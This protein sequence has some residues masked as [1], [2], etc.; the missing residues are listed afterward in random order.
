MKYIESFKT[1]LKREA[2]ISLDKE[3]IS[4]LNAKGGTIYVGVDDSGEVIGI[5]EQDRDN[6]DKIISEIITNNIKP[7]PRQFIKHY[8][9]DDD[10]LVIEI[11]EGNVKPYYLTKKG[12]KNSGTFIRIGTSKRECTDEEILR[13]I[14]DSRFYSYENEVSP[15]QELTFEKLKSVATKKGLDFSSR[16]YKTLKLI[17]NDNKYTRLALLVSDQ[18]DIVIKLAV[19]DKNMDFIIKKDING[20]LI[21]IAEE[22]L[23]TAERCNDV[24]AVIRNKQISRIE[25]LSYPFPSLRESLLNALIHADYAVPSNIKVD[26]FVDKVKI[27]NPGDV[28][29]STIEAAIE[30]IQTF[31][32]PGLTNIFYKLGFIENYGS[33]LIRIINAY[34]GTGQD[35]S[36][37]TKSY[38]FTTTLPNLNFKPQN[39]VN[40]N[41]NNAFSIDSKPS[42]EEDL[43]HKNRN[44]ILSQTEL[45]I[46][47]LIKKN[48]E[49]TYKELL[50]TLNISLIKLRINLYKLK[51][52][53]IIKRIGNRKEGYFKFLKEI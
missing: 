9:N 36:F 45:E 7:V 38:Y 33:G 52:K 8:F 19:Y 37:V 46:L 34:K 17:N 18:N 32:N 40:I 15:I 35:P 5:K 22:L 41:D 16:K 12:P 30:G 10:V 20:S 42:K 51:R 11:Q 4:F 31:R 39:G 14:M 48:K 27:S 50:Y 29:H 28:Y 13:F 21:S 2:T 3:I 1:E 25:L 53:K 43:N 47:N 6:Y 44:S 23:E 26:F 24:S 49:I